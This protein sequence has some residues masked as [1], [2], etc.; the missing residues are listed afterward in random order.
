MTRPLTL[1]L[2]STFSTSAIHGI[3]AT[4]FLAGSDYAR[5]S[6]HYQDLPALGPKAANIFM[7]CTFESGVTAQISFCPVSGAVI[8]RAT[9]HTLDQIFFLNIPIWNAFDSP[10]SVVHVRKGEIVGKYAGPE[11]SAGTEDFVLSGFYN[12]NAQFFNDIRSGRAP[13]GNIESGRQSV[14]IAQFIRE[15]RANYKQDRL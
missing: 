3:D 15:R 7:D 8:E 10:G 11:I 13:R 12:E 6:Y 14:E 9:I 1:R 4:R 2:I 5:V